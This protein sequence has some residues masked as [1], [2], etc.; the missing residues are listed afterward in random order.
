[1]RFHDIAIYRK[2]VIQRVVGISTAVDVE[3]AL[4]VPVRKSI[5]NRMTGLFRFSA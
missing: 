5:R 4:T 2:D 3:Y 1:M